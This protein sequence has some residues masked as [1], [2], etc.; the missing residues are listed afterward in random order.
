M[1]AHS[2]SLL[3]TA[4]PRTQFCFLPLSGW[5]FG[6][7]AANIP[8]VAWYRNNLKQWLEWTVGLAI[9]WQ[10]SVEALEIEWMSIDAEF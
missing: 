3:V 8:H 1:A 5:D 6:R 4:E 2:P 9:G 10:L 7:T